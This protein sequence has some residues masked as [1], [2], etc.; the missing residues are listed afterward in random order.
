MRVENLCQ[1]T[2]THSAEQSFFFSFQLFVTWIFSVHL[3]VTFSLFPLLTPLPLCQ[4]VSCQSVSP[5]GKPIHSSGSLSVAPHPNNKPNW[6]KQT[7]F[8]HGDLQS[9]LQTRKHT[10]TQAHPKTGTNA[11]PVSSSL[12]FDE[13][14]PWL[15]SPTVE[16]V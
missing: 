16:Q 4:P 8:I 10:N 3:C 7:Q 15:E 1:N 6:I 12:N 2:H 14:V 9:C 11:S 5:L 13:A